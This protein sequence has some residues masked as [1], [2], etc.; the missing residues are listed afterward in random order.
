M[1]KERWEQIQQSEKIEAEKAEF[2]ATRGF[3]TVEKD[4]LVVQASI[5]IAICLYLLFWHNKKEEE[6]TR[7]P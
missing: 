3:P 7:L 1:T 2:E 5:G 6:Q 4:A